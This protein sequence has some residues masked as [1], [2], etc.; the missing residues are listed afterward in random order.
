MKR[1][2][3]VSTLTVLMLMAAALT[4]GSRARAD[5]ERFAIVVGNNRGL[6]HEGE[7]RY[8]EADAQKVHDTLRDIGDFAP[9]NI[10]LHTGRSAESLRRTLIA[11]NDRIRGERSAPNTQAVLLVYYSGHADSEDLHLGESRLAIEELS[12]LVRG[13]SADFRLLLLDAC[14]SGVLTRVK[15]GRQ[16]QPFDIPAPLEL[17]GEGLA[18]LTASAENELA[19]ESDELGGSFFTHALISGL[20][21]AADRD[22]DGNVLLDEA[23]QYA[24]DSTLRASSRSA[25]GLQHPTFFYDLRGQGQLVLSRPFAASERRGLLELPRGVTY[26]LFRDDQ[27]GKVAAELGAHDS[28]RTLSLAPGTY[29]V[30]GRT[31]THVLEGVTRVEAAKV[32]RLRSDALT[33]LEYAHLLR[34]GGERRRLHAVEA[35]AQVRTRL[36]NADTACYGALAG[37]R[38]DTPHSSWLVRGG[39]CTSTMEHPSFAS[40]T[41]ELHVGLRGVRALDLG[42]RVSIE[43]GLG[44]AY[45]YTR[46]HFD[47]AGRAPTRHASAPFGELVAGANVALGHG[48][49]A[50]LDAALQCF[51]LTMAPRIGADKQLRAAL[52]TR[53]GLGAG[54][55]F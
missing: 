39:F 36:P 15:G 51:L 48:V 33:R 43:A 54:T 17:H 18:F 46:Q 7:L 38:L 21:G 41:D 55:R 5:V 6:A 29:F 31:N 27:H 20:L 4:R 30:R 47:S 42:P 23:Y 35:L 52:S 3:V 13:S 16:V 26:L 8:A 1:L 22:R 14:R 53:I 28:V 24:Y 44:L 25:R 10:V 19:Q 45:A 34:K 50:T 11:L 9:E 37:Y 40:R 32:T 49:Y 2:A 12:Q